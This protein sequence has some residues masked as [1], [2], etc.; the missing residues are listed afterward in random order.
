SRGEMLVGV[1]SSQA[2]VGELDHEWQRCVVERLRRR[3]G[4]GARHVCH[5][6]MNDAVDLEGRIG[7]RRGPRGLEAAALIDGYVDEHGAT[8]HVREHVAAD[9]PRRARSGNE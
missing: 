1:E 3:D 6:V 2:L 5:A 4:Y 9:E 8:L 7:V